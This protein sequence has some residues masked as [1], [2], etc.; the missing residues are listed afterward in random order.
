MK[1]NVLSFFIASFFVCFG[2]HAHCQMPCGIYHDDMVYDQIDQY[3]ETMVKAV[4]KIK[5]TKTT[6][7][8]NRNE[9]VRWIM[10]KDRLSDQTANLI[11][12]FFLMQKIKPDEEETPK[13]VV[14][15]HK[16]LFQIV[17]IKQT[18][19]FKSVSDFAEEWEKFKLMFHI[20]GYECAM[21]KKNLKIWDEKRKEYEEKAKTEQGS[22]HSNGNSKNESAKTPVS[23]N[24]KAV[25]NGK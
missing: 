23:A 21:E 7:P 4:A 1:K 8:E 5:D 14:S 13:K 25:P 9:Y 12:T 11:T 15:A 17:C 6:T 18:V 19:D 20:Q 16:L 24:S 10:T 3:V 2:L 22:V